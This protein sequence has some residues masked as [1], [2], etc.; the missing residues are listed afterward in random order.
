MANAYA[1][2]TL[3]CLDKTVYRLEPAANYHKLLAEYVIKYGCN[4][5]FK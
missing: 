1:L 4:V 3:H 5:V 2:M